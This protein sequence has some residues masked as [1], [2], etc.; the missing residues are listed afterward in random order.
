MA[1][2][3]QTIKANAKKL[4]KVAAQMFKDECHFY[5]STDKM[6]KNAFKPD[7]AG[8]SPGDTISVNLP[9]R[10][11]PQNTFDITGNIQDIVE[12]AV[13]L[14]L[15]VISTIGVD[16]DSQQLAHDI[17]MPE[18]A[19]RVIKP[20]VSRIAQDVEKQFLEKATDETFNLVGT[21]GSTVHDTDT[22]LSA[23]EKM[24]KFLCPKDSDRYYLHDSTA[25]RSAVNARKGLFQSSSKI[26]EQYEQGL[27]GMADGFLW[28]E[29]EL[30]NV[31]TNGN[32]ITGVA[33]EA[34][35]V[36]PA[37]GATTVGVDGLTAT[38]GTVKKGQVFTIANVFAVHPITKEAYPFLQQFVVTADATANGSGQATLS[39]SPTI[40]DSSAANGLQNVDALHADEAAITFVGAASTAYTQSLAFHKLAFRNV[41]VPLEMPKNAEFAE[42]VT[43]DGVSIALIRDFDVLTR[44]F[45]TRMDFLGGQVSV[46]P[47]WS[48]RVTS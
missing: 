38:T 40:Y 25:C 35:V 27:V 18:V 39:I 8:Y 42:Q 20:A 11:T 45:I 10:F 14:P 31:H 3:L 12:E 13:D 19:E 9:A 17:N 2:Q 34:D 7:D 21:A 26:K 24:S 36:T 47:E 6:P 43:E 28:L 1:D 44:K 23:R 29:N 41:S 46:R 32:D 15:D 30:L 5:K 16:L 22:I 33:V 4:A 48:C 37:S